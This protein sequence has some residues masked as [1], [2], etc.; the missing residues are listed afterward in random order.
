[1]SLKHRSGDSPNSLG[2]R[3]SLIDHC[4]AFLRSQNAVIV[5]YGVLIILSFVAMVMVWQWFAQAQ[6][7]A[8]VPEVSASIGILGF[9]LLVVAAIGVFSQGKLWQILVHMSPTALLMTVFPLIMWRLADS[10]I[11]VLMVAITVP[12]AT[13]AAVMPTYEPLARTSRK[14]PATFFRAF[15]SVWPTMMLLSLLPLSFFA[16]IMANITGW[17]LDR[18]AIYIIGLLSNLIFAQ[19][20]IAAQETKHHFFVFLGWLLYATS[21]LLAPHLWFVIPLMGV[22]PQIFLM[23]ENLTGLFRPMR[24]DWMTALMHTGFGFLTGSVLW[25]DKFFLISLNP[26]SVDVLMV[27]VALVPVVVALSMYYSTQFP[28]VENSFRALMTGVNDSPLNKLDE[29]IVTATKKLGVSAVSTISIAAMSGAGILLLSGLLGLRHNA[30]SLVLFLLPPLLLSLYLSTSQLSQMQRNFP[31]AMCGGAYACA[32]AI[33]FVLF[34]PLVGLYI[35]CGAAALLSVVAVVCVI[36]GV[37]RTP[38]ELFWNKA[39]SW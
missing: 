27:Y 18:I 28:V 11:V 21:L 16:L 29:D 37:A 3:Q 20:L 8:G 5:G 9:V 13:S 24:I 39:V 10:I 22:I 26:H 25:A 12:W 36:R 7:S 38:Y 17:G 15:A 34:S 23:G 30:E 31:A 14:D 1:M 2:S 4:R 19:S 32:V 35:A 6:A 33:G